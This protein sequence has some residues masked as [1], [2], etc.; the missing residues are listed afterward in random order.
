[1]GSRKPARGRT[2]TPGTGTDAPGGETPPA[3]KPKLAAQVPKTLMADI[4]SSRSDP[5]D[6]ACRLGD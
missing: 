4:W 6:A 3:R 1:M 2:T 5:T